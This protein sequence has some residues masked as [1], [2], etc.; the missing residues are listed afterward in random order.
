MNVTVKL[1]GPFIQL[2]G[3]SERRIEV[4]SATTVDALVVSLGIDQS[5]PMIVTRNG[6]STAPEEV[7]P[8]GDR[9]A[10]SPIYSG[11]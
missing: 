9:I 1:I 2:L 10:I 11:G 5:R 6:C 7:L 3:F 8:A 4:P